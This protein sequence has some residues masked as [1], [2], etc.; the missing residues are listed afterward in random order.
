MV[1]SQDNKTFQP[2]A[3]DDAT[4]KL[5][6]S[7]ED[8]L[9]AIN[10]LSATDSHTRVKD[11]A[12]HLNVKMPSVNSA[13]KILMENELIVHES[14]GHVELTKK[15]LEYAQ[16]IYR[17]HKLI[18]QF[19]QEVLGE[20]FEIADVD[21]CRV[22][23]VL[24]GETIENL[25]AFMRVIEENSNN[26]PEWLTEFRENARNKSVTTSSEGFIKKGLINLTKAP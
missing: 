24:S 26:W 2:L 3:K 16:E 12:L 8:Y 10:I 9:E 25:A 6:A 4:I 15:G 22:E 14:Y 5:S 20:P 13:L 18:S 11:I 19:L 23:H 21:A 1:K 17:R 7:I